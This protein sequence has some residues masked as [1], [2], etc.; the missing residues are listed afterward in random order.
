MSENLP[1]EII[2]EILSPALKVPLNLFA[3]TSLESPFVSFSS[4]SSSTLLVC[5]SWL[6]VAT[7][8]LYSFVIIRSKAQAN[9][10]QLTLQTNPQLGRFVKHLRI[11]NGY[12]MSMHHI[13]SKTPNIIHIVLSLNL[14]DSSDGLVKGLPLINP[15]TLSIIDETDFFLKNQAVMKLI[16]IIED[17]TEKWTNLNKV[18]FPYNEST[19]I[20]TDFCSVL[21]AC[22]TVQTVSWPTYG[23]SLAPYI[24][25]IA[26]CPNLKA[27]EIRP[28]SDHQ[29]QL[30]TKKRYQQYLFSESPP[31]PPRITDPR[32]RTLVAKATSTGSGV[33]VGGERAVADFAARDPDFQPMASTPQPI[34]DLIWSRILFFAMFSYPVNTK[35]GK[36]VKKLNAARLQFLLVSPLFQRLA[37]P[38]LYRFPVIPTTKRL[39]R[40]AYTLRRDPTLGEHIQELDIGLTTDFLTCDTDVGEKALALILAYT[41]NLRRLISIFPDFPA[42]SSI[43]VGWD[44]FCAL[45]DSAGSTLQ[46]ITGL[47]FGKAKRP[48]PS[49][50]VFN[51]FVALRSF[52]WKSD[53]WSLK[54]AFRPVDKVSALALPALEILDVQSP[55]ALP[56]FAK[57]KLPMLRRLSLMNDEDWD[58]NILFAHGTKLEYLQICYTTMDERSIFELCP[59]LTT[60]RWQPLDEEECIGSDGENYNF[61]EALEDDFEHKSLT[62]IIFDK[63]YALANKKDEDNW[64]AFF[65]TLDVAHFPSLREICVPWCVWPTNER[66]IKKSKWVR[67]AEVF[68]ERGIK[69][70]DRAG[71]EWRPRLKLATKKSRRTEES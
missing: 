13:L 36:E 2:S 6:R 42:D 50:A 39:L 20:R 22:A 55:E 3:D 71:K 67:W 5:K 48:G 62:K 43:S 27:I 18:H 16:T 10:L 1:D 37:R 14:R 31:P 47:T 59:N 24:V 45:A 65:S 57:M 60:V 23:H 19:G 49:P 46:E 68:L 33:R 58:A 41:P 34:V 29:R 7:S 26:Q 21:C 61:C 30:A 40:F 70:T 35:S 12:G 66:D 51:H 64:D 9:A 44:D 53:C 4:S 38:Y 56:V 69:M 8:L 28:E 15:T 63:R 11:E 17:C 52:T 54:S 32:L 25:E